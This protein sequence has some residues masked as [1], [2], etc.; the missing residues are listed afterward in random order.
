MNILKIDQYYKYRFELFSFSLLVILFGGVFIPEGIFEL[1]LLPIFY[2]IN[3]IAGIIL[4]SK[5]KLLTKLYIVILLVGLVVLI[6]GFIF[7]LV[8]TTIKLLK[9]S[10]YVIFYV[11]VT[12]ELIKQVWFSK[13]IDKNV[14][15]G[16][17]CGYV[18]IG[19]VGFF[20]LVI[21]ELFTPGSFNGID[22]GL[23]FSEAS[24]SLLY[25]SFTT[26]LTI[27]YGDIT[28]LTTIAQKASLFIGFIGQF[29]LAI[30][31]GIIIGKYLN[32]SSAVAEL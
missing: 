29:Y 1:F 12:Y 19:L 17:M 14:I 10:A 21:I 16:L 15:I 20:M 28:P 8:S 23:K 13:K 32:N 7:D 11:T 4:I 30:L 27:G 24:D 3:I 25:Y 2:L 9:M 6:R 5:N 26:L 31:T 22:T 18:C